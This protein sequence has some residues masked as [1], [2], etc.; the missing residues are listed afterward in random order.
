VDICSSVDTHLPLTKLAAE[1]GLHVVCQKPMAPNIKDSREM[2]D[3][4]TANNVKLFINENFR[5]QAPIRALKKKLD[6]GAIG[7]V[8]KSRI[9]FCTAFPVFE[10]QPNLAELDRFILTDIGTHVLDLARYFFGE[11]NSLYCVTERVNP[12]IKG[13]DVANVLMKMANGSSC[14]AEMSYASRLEFES[15]PQVLMLVEGSDGSIQLGHNYQLKV[16]TASGTRTEIIEPKLYPWINPEYAVTHSSIVDCQRNILG[17]LQGKEAEA[18]GTDY[19][20]S[21]ELIWNCYESSET[22]ELIHIV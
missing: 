20:K 16:T 4:C 1:N 13:E 17:G 22:N 3:I 18:S 12:K 11:V 21:T 8:F 9:S 19:L 14:Y 5:W 6:S 7:K 10:N 2:L 15:F